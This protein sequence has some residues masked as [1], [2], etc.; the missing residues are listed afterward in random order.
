MMSRLRNIKKID[1]HLIYPI[2]T[3]LIIVSLRLAVKVSCSARNKAASNEEKKPS[4]HQA[5]HPPHPMLKP[6]ACASINR[7]GLT[8]LPSPNYVLE[9]PILEGTILSKNFKSTFLIS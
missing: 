7:D 8:M 5:S 2:F 3:L 9:L 1:G 6:L 4:N